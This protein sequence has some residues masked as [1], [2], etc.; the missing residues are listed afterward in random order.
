ML[1]NRLGWFSQ[2]R[3][4]FAR[5]L[6]FGITHFWSTAFRRRALLDIPIRSE[7]DLTR[8]A[9]VIPCSGR[10]RDREVLSKRVVFK[11]V[12]SP[13]LIYPLL[14]ESSPYTSVYS[15]GGTINNAVIA[16]EQTGGNS[17]VETVAEKA[18]RIN[19]NGYAGFLR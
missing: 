4:R 11:T 18:I 5:L 8:R 16:G 12:T 15:P 1:M 7:S 14:V 2:L 19:T 6:L 3:L 17:S 10:E 13:T 9:I